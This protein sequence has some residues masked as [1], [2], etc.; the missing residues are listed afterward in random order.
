MRKAENEQENFKDVERKRGNKNQP[1]IV[2]FY[3]QLDIG[4]GQKLVL[5]FA[6]GIFDYSSN[7][8]NDRFY[9]QAQNL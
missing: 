7:N 5:P 1:N 2:C 8:I 3:R 6:Y 9:R 4:R